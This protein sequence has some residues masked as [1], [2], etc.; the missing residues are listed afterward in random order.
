MPG[1]VGVVDSPIDQAHAWRV[2][3]VFHEWF[4][5]GSPNGV[6]SIH[7]DLEDACIVADLS[8]NVTTGGNGR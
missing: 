1:T 2:G 3:P 5:D 8:R 7:P 6:D 4:P